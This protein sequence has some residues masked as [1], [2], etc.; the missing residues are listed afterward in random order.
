MHQLFCATNDTSEGTLAL[1]MAGSFS[2]FSLVFGYTTDNVF[3]FP[4]I[5]DLKIGPNFGEFATGRHLLAGLETSRK[6]PGT[7]VNCQFVRPL[8]TVI[9]VQ[10]MDCPITA[11]LI[12]TETNGSL[13][14]L[15]LTGAELDHLIELLDEYL[16]I[17]L[18]ITTVK[19][20]PNPQ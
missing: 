9:C 5:F 7:A 10:D 17:R 14:S 3:D 2:G 11:T 20:N 12:V 8:I 4:K 18:S 19:L 13:H 16:D 15:N 1:V 6:S